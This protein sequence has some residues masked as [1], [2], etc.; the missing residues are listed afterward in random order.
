MGLKEMHLPQF[1]AIPLYN[2]NYTTRTLA[3]KYSGSHKRVRYMLPK[4]NWLMEKSKEQVVKFLHLDTA[5]LPADLG[6]K[7]HTGSAYRQKEAAVMGN[8]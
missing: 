4:I 6:T 1:G 5:K 7:L 2:D 3:T 8:G